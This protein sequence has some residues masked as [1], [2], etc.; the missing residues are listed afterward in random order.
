MWKDIKSIC[1]NPTA[2]EILLDVL[3]VLSIPVFAIAGTMALF[4]IVGG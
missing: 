3:A 4:M 1:G 2:K